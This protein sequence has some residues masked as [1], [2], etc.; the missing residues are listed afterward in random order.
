MD[1][2]SDIVPPPEVDFLALASTIK[3][4]NQY[5]RYIRNLSNP[6]FS[7]VQRGEL[8]LTAYELNELRTGSKAINRERK[9][10]LKKLESLPFQGGEVSAL[11]RAVVDTSIETLKQTKSVPLSFSSLKA[12]EHFRTSVENQRDF[13]ARDKTLQGNY[14]N[15]I[16]KNFTVKSLADDLVQRVLSYSPEEFYYIY[17]SSPISIGYLYGPAEQF[18][19]YQQIVQYL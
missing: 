10:R 14:A 6:D 19:K 3:T 9:K 2:P 17:M 16:K 15:A 8:T 12:L 11:D 7:P 13:N 18:V 4:R 5:D 1:I